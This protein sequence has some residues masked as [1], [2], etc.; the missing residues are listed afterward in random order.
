MPEDFRLNCEHAKR[1]KNKGK[2]IG[3]IITEIK[4]SI[5]EIEEARTR[6]REIQRVYK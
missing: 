2:A 1:E 3:G 4:K 6:L 5:K